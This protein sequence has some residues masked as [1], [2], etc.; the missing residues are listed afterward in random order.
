MLP[1]FCHATSERKESHHRT[2]L[3]APSFCFVLGASAARQRIRRSHLG[4][5]E[6]SPENEA[7]EH[8][9]YGWERSTFLLQETFLR[10]PLSLSPLG[11]QCIGLPSLPHLRG[12]LPPFATHDPFL[13][14]P[15]FPYPSLED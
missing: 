5:D 14:P 10:I 2:A 11:K 3:E 1:S 12:P 8:S 6:E 4:K 13:I 15:L 7:F 9:K